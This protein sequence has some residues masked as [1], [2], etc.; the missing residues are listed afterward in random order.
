MIDSVKC[1]CG[2]NMSPCFESTREMKVSHWYCTTC[3]RD[4]RAIY[5]ERQITQSNWD[6]VKELNDKA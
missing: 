2:E 1:K 6:A 5:R 3:G 4:D